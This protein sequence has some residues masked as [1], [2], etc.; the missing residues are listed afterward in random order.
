[1]RLHFAGPLAQSSLLLLWFTRHLRSVTYRGE[2]GEIALAQGPLKAPM[3]EQ[4]GGLLPWPRH[5][6]PGPRVLQEYFLLPDALLFA[7]VTGLDRVAPDAASDRFELVFHFDD[8]P[9]LPERLAVDHIRV[10][11]VP[12]INLFEVS[13]DPIA[14]D[15]RQHEHLLR[16]SGVDP[17]HMEVFEVLEVT[18]VRPNRRDRMRYTPFFAFEHAGQPRDE[19]AY[20]TLRR[21]ASPIDSGLDTY[22]SVMT[23]RDVPLEQSEETL[24]V[25]LVCTNRL[26]AASLRAGDICVATPR[27]P[28]I[29]KFRNITGATPPIAPPLGSDLYW[30]L[31]AHL[32]LNQRSLGEGDNLRALLTLYCFEGG[33]QQQARANRL[34]AQAV[35]QVQLSL[36]RRVLGEGVVRGTKA[37]V[38]VD[39]AQFAGL[40]DAFLFGHAL[41]AWFGSLAPIN[42]FS[43]VQLRL[44][45]SITELVWP[46]RNGIQSPF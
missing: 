35:R 1:M 16:A 21:A 23:P 25:S 33:D 32:G 24:S 12:V 42:S 3:L 14:V 30:R 28:T 34:R 8:A 22:L 17:K 9:A 18:G 44:H 2:H 11:C 38:T 29:A 39:E 31:I 45:P 40:G 5:G 26:L 19:Q 15:P 13:A 43:Q 6:L 37:E 20:F 10:N 41:D 4:G 27:S 46:P 36:V 7:D